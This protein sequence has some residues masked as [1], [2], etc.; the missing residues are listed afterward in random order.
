MILSKIV[1]EMGTDLDGCQI[2][3]VLPVQN[4]YIVASCTETSCVIH[5]GIEKE[6]KIAD[7]LHKQVL[8][9]RHVSTS[10]RGWVTE[11]GKVQVDW[12]SPENLEK[13]RESVAFLTHGCGCKTGCST[14]RCKCVKMGRLCGPG[15]TCSRTME[16]QNARQTNEGKVKSSSTK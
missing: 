7:L 3:V 14:A 9:T 6:E 11:N 15:C 12:D 5:T 16:C 8:S 4:R 1:A 10:L 13:T 2:L